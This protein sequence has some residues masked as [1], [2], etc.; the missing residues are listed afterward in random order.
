LAQGKLTAAAAALAAAAKGTKAE[1]SVSN[2][3]QNVKNRANLEQAQA[4]LSAHAQCR[5]SAL[6]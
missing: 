4:A 1:P 6:V 5:A 2:W 3:A